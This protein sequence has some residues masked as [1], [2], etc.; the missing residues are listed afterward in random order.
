MERLANNLFDY[1]SPYT[2]GKRVHFR[3]LELFV[4]V[5]T[6]VFC[7]EWG[8]YIQKI[9]TVLLPLGIANHIDV[10]FMFDHNISV[11]NAAVI[12]VLCLLGFFRLLTRYAYLGALL[13]F[14]LQYVSRYCLGEISHGSNFVGMSLLGLALA[15]ICFNEPQQRRG[16]T[17]GFLYFFLGLGYT[18]AGVSKLIGTGLAWADGRHLWLWIGERR[19]D[20]FSIFGAFEPN[21][22]QN[23]ILQD[24][25]LA[26]LVLTF[27]LLTELSGVLMWWRRSRYVVI[28]LL[29]GMHI[30]VALAMNILFDMYIYEL[31]LLLP[32]WLLIDRVRSRS[33]AS[34]ARLLPRERH[35]AT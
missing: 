30:G 11:V 33:G 25:R 5:Y 4:V 14:H 19:V 3:L 27:G 9:E 35:P 26:T 8:W 15:L 34:L 2:L 6:L 21:A 12:S 7:W 32:W 1:R 29:I 18:S 24:V 28:L 17:L 16:F 23:L 10:S 22:L 20:T 13:L 31:A